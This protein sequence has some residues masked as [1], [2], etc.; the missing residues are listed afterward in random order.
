MKPLEQHTIKYLNYQTISSYQ[1][2]QQQKWIEVNDLSNSQYY[3]NKF[4][5]LKT[6][7]LRSN[8]CDYNDAYIVA[9]GAIDIKIDAS[10][11]MPDKEIMGNK[12]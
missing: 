8:L 5:R 1:S 6:R 10:D 9:Q 4:T 11:D 2:L 7:M 3:V 12:N